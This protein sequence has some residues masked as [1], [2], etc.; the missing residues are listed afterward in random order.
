[1]DMKKILIVKKPYIDTEYCIKSTNSGFTLASRIPGTEMF[2][3]F[4]N[5]EIP[6][7][8]TNPTIRSNR[9]NGSCKY[10]TL[11]NG[12]ESDAA[13]PK[14]ISD[15]LMIYNDVEHIWFERGW[16]DA[17]DLEDSYQQISVDPDT[18]ELGDLSNVT[19]QCDIPQYE[20]SDIKTKSDLIDIFESKGWELQK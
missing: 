11:L 4:K 6:K 1:M 13:Y 9:Y 16:T 15:Y 18:Y 14:D 12:I 3:F 5:I 10:F 2:D 7:G 20:L 8:W 17:T 19:F